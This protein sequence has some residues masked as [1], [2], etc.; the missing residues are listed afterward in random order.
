[1]KTVGIIAEYNPFHKGHKYH[2]EEARRIT[3]ADYCIVVMS[4]DYVQRGEP[5]LFDKHTRCEMALKCGADLVLELPV[6]Y[7]T[8]SAEYFAS[9]AIAMLDK[10]GVTDYLVF[11]SECGDINAM[12]TIANILAD[13]PEEYKERL[14]AQLKSGQSYPVARNNAIT[15]C[16]K[17][18]PELIS[19]LSTPNNILGIEYLKALIK[20]NS[21]IRPVTITRLGADYHST[22]FAMTQAAALA[23]ASALSIRTAL[24]ENGNIDSIRN[25]LPEPVFEIIKREIEANRLPLFRNDFSALLHYKLLLCQSEG[26]EEYADVSP[27]LS[28]RIRKLLPNFKDYDSFCDELKTKNITYVRVSRALMHILLDIK[29]E[30]YTALSANDYLLYANVLG[31]SKNAS[32]LL[33]S[34]KKKSTIPLITKPADAK[35]IISPFAID[36]YESNITCSHIYE[37]L[38]SNK[39]PCKAKNMYTESPVITE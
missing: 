20:R 31:F 22:K 17:D 8:A 11:G 30:S 13:E 21:S 15:S 5:S 4:G 10:L 36:M 34:I 26:Y 38:L 2:I 12:T 14:K 24:L 29:E 7:S 32:K 28:A 23:Y 18:M 25:Q 35:N 19:I 3:G 33:N 27:E 39:Y 6:C 9:A 16:I 37:G 1:M